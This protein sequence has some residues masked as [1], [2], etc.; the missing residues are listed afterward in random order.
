[1]QGRPGHDRR[2]CDQQRLELEFVTAAGLFRVSKIRAGSGFSGQ[3][4]Q[5][6]AGVLTRDTLRR[7]PARQFS[8]LE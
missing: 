7:G 3:S 1:M 4:R 5:A 2:V 6:L 8:S